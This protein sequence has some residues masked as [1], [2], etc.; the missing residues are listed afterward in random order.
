[1]ASATYDESNQITT[2]GGTSF[3]YDANGN[4]A[5]DGTNSYSWSPRNEMIGIIAAAATFTYDALGRRRSKTVNGTTTQFLF[6]G[7]NPVQELS[8]GTPT[9]NILSG[10]AIDEFFARADATG[11]Q[12]YLGDALGST[13]GTTDG[14][15]SVETAY[16]YE[17][18][19]ATT[20]SGAATTSSFAFTGRESDATGLYFYRARYY[21]P[22]LQRFVS[23]DPLRFGGGINMFAYVENDPTTWVDP[24][25]LQIRTPAQGQPPHSTQWHPNPDGSWTRRYFGPDGNAMQDVDYGQRHGHDPEMHDW[26]WTKRRPRQPGRPYPK[27]LPPGPGPRGPGIPGIP[28]PRGT[29]PWLLPIGPPCILEPSICR[30]PVSKT[31]AINSEGVGDGPRWASSNHTTSELR[32]GFIRRTVLLKDS[33]ISILTRP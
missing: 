30:P 16:T 18:F 4:L 24:L 1:M 23:E 10:L 28:I 22:V 27:E 12:Y 26:D 32:E 6:D 7:L 17:P 21:H 5:S 13:V 25:G 19:G 15:G 3:T 9:A 31:M 2:W 20:T 33:R 14:T 11:N 8:S 29:V